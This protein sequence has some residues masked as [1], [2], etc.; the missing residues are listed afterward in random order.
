M[1]QGINLESITS[2]LEMITTKAIISGGISNISDI[3]SI[4]N[5]KSKHIDG[6]IIG[7]ALYEDKLIGRGN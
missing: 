1:L 5:L 4:Y 6:L 2:I 3:Q 7:K